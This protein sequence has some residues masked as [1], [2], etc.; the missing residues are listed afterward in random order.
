MSFEIIES[1]FR[2]LIDPDTEIETIAEG[3]EFTEGPVWNSREKS[4]LFSDIPSN[5]IYSWSQEKGVNIYRDPSNFANGLTY[6]PDGQLIRCEH[7]SRSVTIEKNGRTQTAASTYNGK[8]LNSPNDVV[9]AK[10][11]S[12][13]FSDPIYGLR[14][15][16]GGPADQELSFQGVYRIPPGETSPL[17]ITDS[18]ERPNG[19]AFSNDENYFFI[20]DTVRQHIRVFHVHDKWEFT[21]GEIWAELW[22]DD[23][24]GRPDGIKVD[25]AGNVFCTGP[26]GIWVFDALATLL[27]RIF[28]PQKTSNLAW[29]EDGNSLFITSSS[30]VYRIR[31][32]TSGE[33]PLE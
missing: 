29:G 2:N 22:D 25:I 3:F 20:T 31:C 13:L 1:K 18:F 8:L 24:V 16:M 7:Q 26:G 17:L 27:G 4:L 33:S 10:D 23:R 30:K 28:L 14:V 11:G 5:K 21:G 6:N 15:G 19:L 32:L 9:C 12:I